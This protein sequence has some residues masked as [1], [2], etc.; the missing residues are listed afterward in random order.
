MRLGPWFD[1][2][3][4]PETGFGTLDRAL[5]KPLLSVESA[6]DP[7][8][9]LEK[10]W[11]LARGATGA[12]EATVTGLLLCSQTPE[13]WLPNAVITATHYSIRGSRI[14]L[15]MFADRIE[16][17]SPGGLPTAARTPNA[18]QRPRPRPGGKTMET[19][20]TIASS[21]RKPATPGSGPTASSPATA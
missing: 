21:A 1:S 15:S 12:V 19:C 7:A 2:Q 8:L 4:V 10:L 20:T 11:L 14:R 6:D 5:W 9:A 18:G 17:N 3:T 13:A 16:I